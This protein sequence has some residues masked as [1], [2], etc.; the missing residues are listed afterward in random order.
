[1]SVIFMARMYS[2]KKGKS[3]SKKPLLKAEWFEYKPEEIERLVCKIAK[4]G[5][6]SA[7][8]GLVLRD[9]YGIPSVKDA[10]GKKIMQVLQ[11]NNLQPKLP[12]DLM[13]L[14]KKAVNLREH[15]AKNKKDY[16]SLRGLELVEG[17]IRRLVKYY[18]RTKKL[19]ADWKYEPERA[20]LIVQ[21]GG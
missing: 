5:L 10:T 6:P 2:R 4:D 21:T 9:Q 13:N 19:P 1:M 7:K 14:L 8:I 11:E 12:E 18:A 16:S 17:K 20:K 3:R 15:M